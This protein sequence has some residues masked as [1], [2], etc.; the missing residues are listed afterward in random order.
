MTLPNAHTVE[1]ER[2]I[3]GYRSALLT[4]SEWHLARPMVTN[5]VRADRPTSPECARISLSFLCRFLWTC[6][7]WDRATEPEFAQIFTS[8]QFAH[9]DAALATE[10]IAANTRVNLA[11]DVRRVVGKP[12]RAK[13]DGPRPQRA[14]VSLAPVTT[15]DR[16]STQWQ[17]R[18]WLSSRLGR[19]MNLAALHHAIRELA[20][21]AGLTGGFLDAVLPYLQSEDSRDHRDRFA[22]AA[23]PMPRRAKQPAQRQK[24]TSAAAARRAAKAAREQALNGAVPEV[25][26]HVALPADIGDLIDNYCPRALTTSEF[27]PQRQVTTQFVA[28]SAPASLRNARRLLSYTYGYVSWLSTHAVANPTV[29]DLCDLALLDRYVTHGLANLS[30]GTRSTQRSTLASAIRVI[31]GGGRRPRPMSYRG[32]SAPYSPAEEQAMILLARHQP[33]ARR[34]ARLSAVVALG[35][36]AGL[37][38][39]DMRAVCPSDIAVIDADGTEIIE[40][41]VRSGKRPRT[42]VLR[43]MYRQ[44]LDD[45]L[46]WHAEAGRDRDETLLGAE[47]DRSVASRVVSDSLTATGQPVDIEAVRLRATWLL[48]VMNARVPLTAILQAAGLK[49]ARPI[50]DLIPYLPEPD[51]AEYARAIAGEPA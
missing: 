45:S 7:A 6:S 11:A 39:S 1:I 30:E 22:A 34:R 41:R 8:E 50:A 25:P 29:A 9:V 15:L 35:A 4:N 33:T 2:I 20:G 16:S 32:G 12:K 36:G 27:A 26:A 51:P 48:A 38:S 43:N 3:H 37:D 23:T 28:A 13:H 40:I 14:Q 18:S 49:S 47:N 19:G 31:L 21:R 24:P 46:Q 44:L 10:G 17:I 42:V 5:L